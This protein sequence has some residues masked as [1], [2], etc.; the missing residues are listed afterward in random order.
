MS[1][2]NGFSR[3][4]M[5]KASALALGGGLLLDERLEAYPKTVNTNS[6]PSALKITDV[7]VATIVK[8]GPSPCPILRIDTY[9]GL[10]GLGVCR[11]RAVATY[12]LFL[13][14]RNVVAYPL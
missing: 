14:S 1:K 7:R 6:S 2:H 10:Y 5:V 9:Q 13:T 11:V 12:A 4:D 8:P 3:R